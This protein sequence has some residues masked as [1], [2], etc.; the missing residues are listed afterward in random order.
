MVCSGT[1]PIFLLGLGSITLLMIVLAGR[2]TR[3][4]RAS[5]TRWALTGLILAIGAASTLKSVREWVLV[6]PSQMKNGGTLTRV[7][8]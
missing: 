6:H 3:R 8:V 4:S 2:E 7:S 1:P 5:W